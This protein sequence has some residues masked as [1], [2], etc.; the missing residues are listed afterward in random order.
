MVVR[1]FLDS[2]LFIF[3]LP[4]MGSSV[5]VK[6]CSRIYNLYCS[7]LE[8]HSMHAI[9]GRSPRVASKFWETVCDFPR[10]KR[11]FSSVGVFSPCWKCCFSVLIL[12]FVSP[13]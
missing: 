10:K 9:S 12:F 2:L 5:L 6:E 7:L 13:E 3:G 8:H 4:A 1:F 11:R